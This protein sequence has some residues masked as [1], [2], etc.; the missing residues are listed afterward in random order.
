MMR[1]MRIALI[2]CL[3]A[4]GRF[5]FAPARLDATPDATTDAAPPGPGSFSFS[6]FPDCSQLALLGSA[7]CVGGE[8]EITPSLTNAAGAAWLLQTYDMTTLHHIAMELRIRM[9]VGSADSGDGMTLIVQA[10]PRGTGAIGVGG[11][12]LGIGSITPSTAIELD[13]FKNL[14]FVPPETSNNHI[15]V[16]VD[17]DTNST[18]TATPG[19]TMAQTSNFS[20]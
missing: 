7:A 13:T 2:C 6:D 15:G 18:I 5:D 17:G 8:L 10:D 19:F 1:D 4:C 12:E 3:V 16:D 9:V 14:E 20:V 11:G